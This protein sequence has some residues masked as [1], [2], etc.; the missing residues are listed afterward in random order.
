MNLWGIN[1]QIKQRQ[2]FCAYPQ[3]PKN[4]MIKRLWHAI[5]STTPSSIQKEMKKM[6]RRKE[7]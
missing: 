7:Y 3:L 4:F 6:I 5:K 2:D 1:Q